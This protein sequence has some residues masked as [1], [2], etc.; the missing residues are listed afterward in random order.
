VGEIHVVGDV[1]VLIADVAPK[2]AEADD[3]TG[4]FFVVV[5]VV[6]GSAIHVEVRTVG[7][8]EILETERPEPP[9]IWHSVQ[10]A[11]ES[12]ASRHGLGW[13]LGR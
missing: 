7:R 11:L 1:V 9:S 2:A 5:G 8:L 3:I 13:F 4:G 6:C 10:M 12:G